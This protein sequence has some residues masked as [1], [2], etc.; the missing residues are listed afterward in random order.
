M[1]TLQEQVQDLSN[2]MG[3]LYT[4]VLFIGVQNAFAVQPVVDIESTIFYRDRAAGMYSVLPYAFA[5]VSRS[6]VFVTDAHTHNCQF[7]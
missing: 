5:Q 4:L 1:H 6:Y 7:I 3:S 2:A